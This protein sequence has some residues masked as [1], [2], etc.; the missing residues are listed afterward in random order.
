[1]TEFTPND[2]MVYVY[3]LPD[4]LSTG[5][6]FGGGRPITFVNVDWFNGIDGMTREMLETEVRGKLYIRPGKSYLV[7]SPDNDI[8]F[9]LKKTVGD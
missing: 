4:E 6:C 2:T 7:L 1:M 3:E 8:S 5:Y 9:T